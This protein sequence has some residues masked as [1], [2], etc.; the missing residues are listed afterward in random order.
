[1]SLRSGGAPCVADN[2]AEGPSSPHASLN[3]GSSF[4]QF[5]PR[6]TSGVCVAV[7]E[8]GP[9]LLDPSTR[10][11]L[12]MGSADAGA[13]DLRP[14]AVVSRATGAGR[15]QRRAPADGVA[16]NLRRGRKPHQQIFLLRKI[17]RRRRQ[18][19]YISTVP[20]WLPLRC[21]SG[22]PEIASALP[23]GPQPSHALAQAFAP[24]ILSVML[25]GVASLAYM[26]WGGSSAVA[27][28]R[29]VSVTSL[30]GLESSPSISPDGNLWCSRGRGRIRKASP[31]Y[32][33][34]QSIAIPVSV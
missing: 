14:A 4:A 1:M 2:A 10:S 30:P 28:P 21:R 20:R 34:A 8:F 13:Q 15:L 27:D 26:R 24:L 33:S 6:L 19:E 17:L 11:L 31:I 3:A 29:I 5:P 9:F 32:G 18:P 7:F 25:A 22:E 12:R 16:R 23:P